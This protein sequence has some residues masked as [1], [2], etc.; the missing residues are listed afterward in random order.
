MVE[1]GRVDL[2]MHP[3]TQTFLEMK[4]QAY[5]KYIHLSFLFIYLVFLFLITFFSLGYLGRSTI[6]SVPTNTTNDC[7][8]F[9]SISCSPQF[10][11]EFEVRRGLVFGEDGTGVYFKAF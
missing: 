5:G 2:L 6:S 8:S 3:L 9:A 11:F 10:E 7:A 4:W 1:S